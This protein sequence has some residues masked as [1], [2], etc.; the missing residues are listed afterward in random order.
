MRLVCFQCKKAG[1]G[2]TVQMP[3]MVNKMA[4]ELKET[5]EMDIQCPNIILA[6][7][8]S[9]IYISSKS[10]DIFYKKTNPNC[11]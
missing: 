7:F 4:G 10:I 8:F 3:K 9:K 2:G 11:K 1:G 5:K 6:I